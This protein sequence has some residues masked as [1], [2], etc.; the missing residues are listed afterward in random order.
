MDRASS[1]RLGKALGC[2]QETG[3]WPVKLLLPRDSVV[4]R[5]RPPA[6]DLGR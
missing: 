1:Y 3:T 2:V 4:T 5:G 6:H